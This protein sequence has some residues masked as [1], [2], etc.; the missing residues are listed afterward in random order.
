[1]TSAELAERLQ[2]RPDQGLEELVTI[3]LAE[4][5]RAVNGEGRARR[6]LELSRSD[7]GTIHRQFFEIQARGAGISSVFFLENKG[8][9]DKTEFH[10]F[11]AHLRQEINNF[12][13]ALPEARRHRYKPLLVRQE[14]LLRQMVVYDVGAGSIP[15][16][17]SNRVRELE[18]SVLY[19]LFRMPTGPFIF[20]GKN[21][22]EP[23]RQGF[24]EADD[25]FEDMV[26]EFLEV[27][28]PKSAV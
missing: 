16:E 26:Q 23:S 5:Y 3:A 2:Y 15:V 12:L 4:G 1:L 21:S 22:T 24:L 8:S 9:V 11:P 6:V 20:F 18:I 14:K 10:R 19:G 28:R 27:F 25:H 13:I 17:F 7:S